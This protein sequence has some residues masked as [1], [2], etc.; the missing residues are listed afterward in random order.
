MLIY[1]SA[2]GNSR[3]C[4]Q[5]LASQLNQGCY[6]ATPFIRD[7]IPLD[8][9][10]ETPWIFV[11]PT[12]A[13]Q[14]PRVFINFIQNSSFNGNKN[15][16]F[17]M[18]C[19]NDIGNAALRNQSLCVEKGL[20][21]RGTFPVVMPENYIV[22]FKAPGPEKAAQIITAANPSIEEI[23]S[24]IQIG[25]DFPLPK[26]SAFSKLKSGIVN[27]LFYRYNIKTTRFIVSASCI[28][29]GKCEKLCPLGNI[30]IQAGH[31][32]WG[33]CCTHCMACISGCPTEAIDYGKATRGKIRYHFPAN[34]EN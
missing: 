19:G 23:R 26:K 31:P 13:W 30:Q 15:A 27:R 12:Y 5:M 3:Y 17:I 24:C 32:V 6:D 2:T 11:S 10:S 28:S 4:A 20:H 22:M 34:L 21:Y 14:L 25:K 29:C 16:Y 8:L 18:T 7:N 33:D 1:F 9:T